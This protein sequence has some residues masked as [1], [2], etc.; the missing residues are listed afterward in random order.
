MRVTGRNVGLARQGWWR[1]GG[2]GPVGSSVSLLQLRV[3][4]TAE[5]G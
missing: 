3:Q 1:E 5:E 2:L 4:L